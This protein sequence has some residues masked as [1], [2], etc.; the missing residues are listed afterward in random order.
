MLVVD[1]RSGSNTAC[2]T[3]TTSDIIVSLMLNSDVVVWSLLV[4][5]PHSSKK[6]LRYCIVAVSLHGRCRISP[7]GAWLTFVDLE[8]AENRFKLQST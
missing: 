7:I 1:R 4:V 5:F 8:V 2:G 3:A 6:I